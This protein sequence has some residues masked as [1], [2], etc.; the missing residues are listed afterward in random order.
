M[1]VPALRE[2][3]RVLPNA[4]VTLVSQPG[5]ADI[6]LDADFIDEVLVCD[7]SGLASKWN[8]IREWQQRK[9]DLAILFQN[10]FE[11]A[12]IAFLARVPIRIGYGTERRS[13]LLTHSAR[14]PAWKNERHESFYYLNIVAELDRLIRGTSSVESVAPDFTLGVSESRKRNALQT[15][16][17]HG[18]RIGKPLV[19]LC[20]GSINSR[21]KRWPADR[22]AAL[23]D[24][25]MKSGATVALIGSPA[26]LDV[27]RQ[28]CEQAVHQ[29]IMLTGKTTVADATAIISIA[30]VLI[31]NDTGPAHIGAALNTPTL[32]VFGPTNPLTTY[33]LSRNAEI[34]RHPPE[35]APCMLRDCP[36]DHRCMTAITVEEVFGRACA[37]MSRRL[38]VEL[39]T[40]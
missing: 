26:E 1:S 28:V 17:E 33:P 18:T 2:L 9:F 3:R 22:Y 20:P 14:V 6:F 21:A 23:A 13:A 16:H 39:Q 27:S 8:Q 5:T 36:I 15:L 24:Q 35:C 25:L 11:A 10:A 30:D 32:V 19:L 29:P 31:T 34:I 37:M 7:R 40:A 38:K 12:A 4:N